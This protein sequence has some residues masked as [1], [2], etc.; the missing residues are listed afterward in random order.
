MIRFLKFFNPSLS[1][2]KVS[3]LLNYSKKKKAIKILTNLIR[4]RGEKYCTLHFFNYVRP[5][6]FLNFVKS[7]FYFLLHRLRFPP[8][9]LRFNSKINQL[10]FGTKASKTE[11]HKKVWKSFWKKNFYCL[12]SI[13]CF[14]FVSAIL[15]L[16]FELVTFLNIVMLN[17]KEH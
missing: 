13:K 2:I 7:P 4:S 3:F 11:C 9:R 17:K 12:Q 14:K 16:N 6:F 5:P 8:S 10:C 1:Q 15:I